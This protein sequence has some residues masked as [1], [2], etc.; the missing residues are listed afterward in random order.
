MADSK[1]D[2]NLYSPLKGKFSESPLGASQPLKSI[3]KSLLLP[4]SFQKTNSAGA[5]VLSAK[6]KAKPTQPHMAKSSSAGIRYIAITSEYSGGW[7]VNSTIRVNF[8]SGGYVGGT[9]LPYDLPV[10]VEDVTG[11]QF[12]SASATPPGTTNSNSSL[13]LNYPAMKDVYGLGN[14]PHSMR[15]ILVTFQ[16]GHT[17]QLNILLPGKTTSFMDAYNQTS[18]NTGQGI[19]FP[20]CNLHNW[21]ESEHKAGTNLS[22]TDYTRY[23]AVDSQNDPAGIFS[24]AGTLLAY[25]TFGGNYLWAKWKESYETIA[26]NTS[27]QWYPEIG[28][29]GAQ[30]WEILQ[31]NAPGTLLT[32]YSMPS[33]NQ[34]KADILNTTDYDSWY[35]RHGHFYAE[36]LPSCTLPTTTIDGCTDPNN[37]AYWGYDAD[38]DG[39][40]EDCAGVE[41]PASI[42]AD[43]SL[44]D[45]TPGSCCPD[46]INPLANDIILS[47]QPLTLNV[48]G[49]DPTTNGGTDGYINVTVVDQGFNANG[50]PQGLPTGVPSY[51]YV[52]ENTNALDTMCG[53]SAGVKIGSGPLGIASPNTT[54]S[55]T[56]GYAV[57]AN[58]NGGLL[59]TGATGNATYVASSALGYVPAAAGTT[60]NEG[61]RAGT[62]KVYVFDANLSAQCLAQT[63]ITLTEPAPIVGCTDSNALNYD[64]TANISGGT[65]SC[66]YCNQYYGTLID[67]NSISVGNI[68]SSSSTPV[69]GV[70]VSSVATDGEIA[71]WGFSATG[72]FQGYINNIVDSNGIQN[73]DYKI[74]LYRWDTQAITGNSQWSLTN[75]LS[76]FNANTTQ[77]GSTINNQGAGWNVNLNTATLGAGITYG[78]YTVKLYVDDPDATVEQEQCYHLVNVIIKVPV[79][80][81]DNG[82]ATTSDGVIISDSNL[83]NPQNWVCAV[84]D[85]PC[86][87]TAVFSLTSNSTTCLLEYQVQIDC[88]TTAASALNIF[89]QFWDGGSWVSVPNT[90][91][92]TY[93]VNNPGSSTTVTF[94]QSVFN[95]GSGDYRVEV[96]SEFSAAPDCTLTTN[97][98]TITLGTYGCTDPTA[99]NYDPTATCDEACIYCVYGCTDPLALNYNSLATCEDNSCSYPVPGCTDMTASNYNPAATVDDGSCIYLNCGCTDPLAYN[100]GY[101]VAGTLVG[102]PPSCDDGNCQYCEDPAMDVSFTAT[103]TTLVSPTGCLDNCDGSIELTVT[104][105][106]GCTNYTIVSMYMFC[107]IV[108]SNIYVIQN[109]NYT[110][111]TTVLSNLCSATWTFILEDCN[112]CQMQQEVTVPGAGGPCGCTDPAADNYCASCTTDDGSCEYCGCTDDG[113]INYN[114]EATA[115]CDPN[116]CE[117]PPLLPPCIPPTIDQTFYQ[118]E[119]CIASNGFSYYNKMLSGQ[120]DDCSV[121]NFWKLILIDYLLKKKGL[122]CIYNCADANTPDAADAYVS[123]RRLWRIGGTTTG[124]GD[125]IQTAINDASD[126]PN[127]G[128]TSTA[129][130]FDASSTTLLYPGD[131][132]KHHNSGI[133]WIFYGPGGTGSAGVSVAGLDPENASGNASG[134]WGY[135]NNNMRYISN[136]NNINYIDN[137]INFANTFCADCGNNINA[138]IKIST[139]YTGSA[140]VFL[141]GDDDIEI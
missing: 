98:E 35:V 127:Y 70:P 91:G 72:A 83:Q 109:Q 129:E 77:V 107:G 93:W 128:T 26:T 19:M 94:P 3:Y 125:P 73:A 50:I 6:Y 106:T 24:T 60:N 124:F 95:Y 80:V 132:I 123:C 20:G 10:T 84:L 135:C 65:A 15:E 45:W 104:S 79:C 103:G 90:G 56:F 37:M 75:S 118:L 126:G 44:A 101:N 96:V 115:N 82:V 9:S 74:E 102:T 116:T 131:V 120:I 85:P 88:N 69:V 17:Q 130:M 114:P 13:S 86:C 38:A 31:I 140:Q 22:G 59:Q 33:L 99:L 43:P 42:Q 111:G 12:D 119:I 113:A 25:G 133:I 66:H 71:L 49:T 97:L 105:A 23:V 5:T 81:D 48:S 11:D 136:T 122:D 32:S 51:T 134:Y 34:L 52:L 46:C 110:T 21:V 112:G 55:F 18:A 68:A 16:S 108:N 36:N 64:A 58:N 117:Y 2:K 28:S 57:P 61:L 7:N 54:G 27:T 30:T 138:P 40:F 29:I 141:E 47:T 78:Y 67:G 137:F 8:P 76:Q 100:Y 1:Y 14:V 53:N 62:Y 39:I 92:F 87:D 89:L 4:D 63:Q 41:I 139:G 121:L